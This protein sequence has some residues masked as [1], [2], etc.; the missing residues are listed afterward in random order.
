MNEIPSSKFQRTSRFVKTGFQ[1][2]GNYLK[3]YAQKLVNPEI[4]KEELDKAN[5]SDIYDAL[6]ELKGSALKVAQML[7]MDQGILP[8]SYSTK[9]A[10]SQYKAPALSGPLVVKTF[11]AHFGKSPFELFETFDIKAVHAASI[12]QVHKAT[13]KDRTLAVKIQYPGVADS[14][15][16]DL[17][18]VKPVAR[19]LFGWK[20]AELSVYF[21]EVKDRL[22]EETR[23]DLEMQ[24]G[25]EIAT[26]CKHIE[27]LHFPVYYP[28][29]STN[30]ILTMDWMEGMHLNE[31]LQTNPSQETRNKAAQAIWNFYN[32]QLHVLNTMHADAHPG[33][34]LFKPDGSVVVLDFGCIKQFPKE[35][36]ASYSKIMIPGIMENPELFRTVCLEM[37]ALRGDETPDE[38]IFFI[39]I[40]K[41]SVE[42]LLRPFY[43]GKYD[44]SNKS[45]FDEL[46]AYGDKL[47]EKRNQLSEKPRGSQHGIYLNR[48]YFGIY[49]IMHYLSAQIETTHFMTPSSPAMV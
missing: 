13:L 10:E 31:F 45:Y 49:N 14:V 21:E 16:S 22:I 36:Y 43:N 33:N 4:E 27:N 37:G 25:T 12:G 34:F 3:H 46:Y 32:Y 20:E 38:E 48:T 41:E 2:G 5:A 23:Y 28:K 30:R 15:T 11:T 35:F 39:Q 9:F 42:L 26:A 17:N 29:Y 24:R 47:A 40:F 8:S 1:I 18:F 7:S 19:R 6:S 44:F